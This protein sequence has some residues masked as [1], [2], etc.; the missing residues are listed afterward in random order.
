VLPRMIELLE[1]LNDQKET[2]EPKTVG[3]GLTTAS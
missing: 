2:R 3:R 1:A